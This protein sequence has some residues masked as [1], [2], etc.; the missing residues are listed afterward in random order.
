VRGGILP[1]NRML[2]NVFK[3]EGDLREEA[4]Q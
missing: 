2:G 1:S 3:E 4:L